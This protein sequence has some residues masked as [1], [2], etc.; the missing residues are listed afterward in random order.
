MKMLEEKKTR[1]MD[2]LKQ[3]EMVFAPCVW[4]CYSA[5]AAALYKDEVHSLTKCRPVRG[6]IM[7]NQAGNTGSGCCCK[8]SLIKRSG[9]SFL[10]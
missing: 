6:C 5:K 1:F 7:N 9:Y 4:D 2:L 10:C 8:C 3:G